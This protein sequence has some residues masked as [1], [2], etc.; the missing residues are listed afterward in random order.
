MVR[1]RSKVASR[2]DDRTARRGNELIVALRAEVS[3]AERDSLA[4]TVGAVRTHLY[5]TF[6]FELWSFDAAQNLGPLIARLSANPAVEFAESNYLITAD[7]LTPNDPRFSEQWALANAGQAGTDI[8][9]LQAWEKTTGSPAT[10]IAIIDSGVDFT[11]PDLSANRWANTADQADGQD[12]DLDTLTDDTYGW[13]WVTG[14][15]ETNYGLEHGT[16][17]AGIIAAHGNN[18]SGGAGVMW[19]ASLM[20]L[21]VLDATGTGDVARAVESVNYAVAHGAQVINCSWGTEGESKALAVALR[22]AD[23]KGVVIVASAGNDGRN[24]DARP[25]YPAAYDLPN[26]IAVAATDRFDQLTSFSNWGAGHAAIAAPGDGLLTTAPSGDYRE[27]SGT[28]ISAALV[29]GVAGLIKTVRPHLGAAQVRESI[30]RGARP[31]VALAGRATSGGVLSVGDT[32]E[33]LTTLPGEPGSDGNRKKPDTRLGNNGS[34]SVNASAI[35]PIGATSPHPV[36]PSFSVGALPNLDQLRQGSSHTPKAPDA[37]PSTQR[38]CRPRRAPCE[39]N[40]STPASAV[41][42]LIRAPFLTPPWEQEFLWGEL[43]RNDHDPAADLPFYMPGSAMTDAPTPTIWTRLLNGYS[44]LTSALLQGTSTTTDTTSNLVAHWKLDESIGTTAGD[45]TGDANTATLNGPYWVGG[46]AGTGALDLNGVN[47]Y[48]NVASTPSI[49]NIANNFTVS[50]WA[51]PRTTHQIDAEGTTGWDGTAGQRYAIEPRYHPDPDAGA[52][53][54]VGTN[55]VS[56]YEHSYGYMPAVLVHQATLTGWT[57]VTVVYQN[58]QPR[59]Y[60]NGVLVRT[61]LTSPRAN[62]RLNPNIGGMVYGYFDGRLDDV[63]IYSRALAG[64]DV[65]ALYSSFSPSTNVATFTNHSAAFDGI[66]GR[67]LVPNGAS[68]NI[69]G[70]LTVEGWFKVADNSTNQVI[71]GNQNGSGGYILLANQGMPQFYLTSN[72]VGSDFAIAWPPIITPGEWHHMAGVADGSQIRVY[73]DGQLVAAKN[74]TLLPSAVTTDFTIGNG[75]NGGVGLHGNVDEVRVTAGATYTANFTPERHL[76]PLSGTRGLWKFDGQTLLDSSG[77]GNN[78]RFVGGAAYSGDLPGVAMPANHSAAFDGTTGRIAVP[79]SAS[80]NVTGA[81]TVEGWFKVTDTNSN[82]PIAGTQNGSG[83]YILLANAGMPQF[84]ITQGG[85]GSDFAIAWPPNITPNEWHHMAGVADGAQI[86]VYLD[87]NLVAAKNSTMLPSTTTTGFAI[88]GTCDGGLGLHGNVDEV[89]V[90]TGALYTANFTPERHPAVVAGTRGLWRLDGQT[91]L[92]SSGNGNNGSFVGGATYSA[93]V[94]GTTRLNFALANSGASAVASSTYAVPYSANTIINGDRKGAG[95]DSGTGGWNDAT[96]NAFPDWA[97]V[98]FSGTK[99]INEI[100]VF[101]IQD[102]YPNPVEPTESMTFATYGITAFEVQYWDGGAWAAVPNG[103][104][105][106]NN[107]VWRKFTFPDITTAKV[108]VLVNNALASY[109]RLTEVE[110]WGYGVPATTSQPPNQ[111]PTV[112]ITAP[113]NNATF[114]NDSTVN[115]T[116]SATDSDGTISKVEFCQNGVKLGEATTAPYSFAWNNVAPGSYSLTAKATDN[117]GASATSSAINITVTPP[118]VSVAATDANASEQGADPGVFTFTRTGGT[119]VPLTLNYSL[120]GTATNGSDYAPLSG[121]LTIPAGASAQTVNVSPIDDAAVEGNETVTLALTSNTAYA[122][123]TPAAATITIADND[124][125]PPTVSITAPTAGT[126]LTAPASVTI[127]AAAADSDGTVAKVEFYQG[128]ALLGVATVTPYA[129]S[130][131]NV[132][133]GTYSL[134]AKA[135]DNAGA[136]TVSSPI[137]VTVNEPPTVSVTTPG[138]GLY[139]APATFIVNA[140][141]SDPDGSIVKVEFFQNGPKGNTKVGEATTVPYTITM[142]SMPAGDYTISAK[143]TDDRGATMT[144]L[145]KSTIK[146]VDFASALIDPANRTGGSGVDLRSGNYNWNLPLLSLPGRAGLDLGLA[147]SCNSRVWTKSGA[148]VTYDADDGFPAPGFR[149]GFPTILPRFFNPQTGRNTYILITPNGD[150]VEL[151]QTATVGVYE[152][153]DSSYLQLIESGAT[154]ILRPPDGAQLTYVAQGSSYVC[155]KI[156]DRNGNF[157]SATYDGTG[158]IT[159]ITDTLGR[160][161]VFNYDAFDGLISISR[162]MWDAQTNQTVQRTWIT[163]GWGSQKIQ[164]SFSGLTVV[165]A[166]GTKHNVITQVGL[167]DGSLYRFDYSS[168]GQ[169]N[170][171]T[172]YTLTSDTPP[173]SPIFP[174]DYTAR[175]SVSYQL[176]SGGAESDCPRVLS[177][178]VTAENWLDGNAATTTYNYGGDEATRVW[179]EMTL[180]AVAPETA[181]ARYKEYF[182]TGWQRGLVIESESFAPNNPPNSPR[183]RTVT[184]W[185]QDDITAAYQINPRIIETNISDSEANRRRTT[186]EYDPSAFRLPNRVCEFAANATSVLRCTT[187][188]YVAA[189]AYVNQRIIGLPSVRSLFDENGALVSK[190]DYLYDQADEPDVVYLADQGAT[191]QH[192]VPE[193]VRANLNVIRQWDTTSAATATNEAQALK[194][195]AGYNTNGSLILSVDPAGHRATVSYADSFS[196]AAYNGSRFAYP[197]KVTD[198]D[199]FS[200]TMSYSFDFGAVTATQAPMPNQTQPGVYGPSR[201]M[202]YDSIGRPIQISN[203]FNSAQTRMVYPAS[204]TSVQSFTRIKDGLPPEQDYLETRVFDGAGRVVAASHDFPVAGATERRYSGQKFIYDTLGR[205]MNR[206]NLTE[207]DASWT[208]TGDDAPPTGFGWVFTAQSYDWKG[209]PTVTTNADGRTTKTASYGGCGCAGGEIVTLTD[210]VGRIQKVYHDVLGRAVKT[211]ILNPGGASVYKTTTATYNA[212]DQATRIFAQDEASGAGQE[213]LMNYDGYGR[214]WKSKAPDQSNPTVRAYNADGTTQSV[215]DARGVITN[216]AYNARHL[217]TGVSYDRH[218]MT[219][220]STE[221]ANGTSGTTDIADTP[222]VIYQYDAAGNRTSMATANGAGGSCTYAYNPL[223]QMTSESRLLPGL[224]GTYMLSYDYTIGGQLKSVTD[225]AAG[226]SFT[227]DYDAAGQITGV[228][229]TGFETATTQFTSGMKYRAWGALK[230]MAYGNG[231]SLALSYDQRGL[232]KHYGVDGVTQD[233]Q[234]GAMAHGSDFDYYDDGRV[235]YASDLFTDAQPFDNYKLHDR[236]YSY[237]H[238]GRLKEAYSGSEANQFESGTASGVLGAFRQSYAYDV[239][240]N[241]TSRTGRFWSAE[242]NDIESYDTRGR[243][244]AWEYDPD[245]R[246]I[247]RNEA[248][249]NALPY[250]PLRQAYDAVGRLSVTTQKTSR[251]RASRTGTTTVFTTQTAKAE[252][253][254]GDGVG[255]KQVTTRQV[256]SNTPTTTATYY[257]RSAVL[258]GRIISEYDAQGA[259]QQS[260]VFAGGKEV[261]HGAASL[262][263]QHRNPVTGDML[264]TNA[265]GVV[266]TK[267]MVDPMGVAVGDSDPFSS[268]ESGTGDTGGGI[269]QAQINARYAQL[270]PESSGGPGSTTCVVDGWQMDCGQ[271]FELIDRGA[272]DQCPD[273]Y[274]GPRDVDGV[275]QPLK[276]DPNTGELGYPRQSWHMEW[277]DWHFVVD[278]ENKSTPDNSNPSGGGGSGTDDD[279]YYVNHNAFGHWEQEGHLVQDYYTPNNYLGTN[280]FGGIPGS[281]GEVASNGGQGG[282]PPKQAKEIIKAKKEP[283]REHPYVDMSKWAACVDKEMLAFYTNVYMPAVLKYQV[284]KEDRGMISLMLGLSPKAWF[285]FYTLELPEMREGHE[286]EWEPKFEKAFHDAKQK[287]GADPANYGYSKD[288]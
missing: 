274:C 99:T 35:S 207:I 221:K 83:G 185:T 173:P 272:A 71:A 142:S 183:K 33:V 10:V 217:V 59:L 170:R 219:S 44:T 84:Y 139:A 248:A 268:P 18:R 144:S 238:V 164:P 174:Q 128:A 153:A 166:V 79:N 208:P 244:T 17:V 143:A 205:L 15:G 162:S 201:I 222:T 87:G 60:L 285:D 226:T 286:K 191:V 267:A 206:S 47:N 149:L 179:G 258:G 266:V 186:I 187:T 42:E 64:G 52:G 63:R 53:I 62:V 251:S 90:T 218:G 134:T 215:T 74:S 77:N 57:H 89:R 129:F 70:A 88:G 225:Q 145:T 167:P 58:K 51:Y 133:A 212:L 245:G 229:G 91:L 112:S 151:R 203:S 204:L 108:R 168:W 76:T 80:L 176:G 38:R 171:I 123:G 270:F 43:A 65:Q 169:V 239:W 236:A 246:L 154:L 39:Q 6:E 253:Y 255:I 68:L 178:T 250:E 135:T 45:A 105:T 184:S 75:W 32:S 82:M 41:G 240:D 49:T 96:G 103:N 223:S 193:G 86:R 152:A 228:S 147:L 247:S 160:E 25:R 159:K 264:E 54:S 220:V 104:V 198:P 195:K 256:N 189:S 23:E 148:Y 8:G 66:S 56:V 233:G 276:R 4:K 127:N 61:G 280:N 121:A 281:I 31:V 95:W 34:E 283:P 163:F 7:S 275:L 284:M 110:A 130:W 180:P 257:L 117:S 211:E 182:G 165:G 131:S 119:S 73:L 20:S 40:G 12:N 46:R 175:S 158:Q 5:G 19:R 37:V 109:S 81:L 202:S 262:L 98:D 227:N 237:D 36:I 97:E 209:R 199:G 101:T 106:G 252:I 102:N 200:S 279:P 22:H 192:E 24:I 161:I 197:T 30:L 120:S 27:A 107:L 92:D 150:H 85:V 146:V 190:V 28:S 93:D 100:D 16:A 155:T 188:T 29:A 67:V 26:V 21:R 271:A 242:D 181:G 230:A 278:R 118:A 196:V 9:V 216:F 234:Y 50:F 213:T 254:D 269:S 265:Q 210:E 260:H 126:V 249:P 263:W 78:G 13:D 172:R 259:R 141:A 137:N 115:L 235:K 214:L 224:T 231:T 241:K 72:G 3:E 273:N 14:S 48:L 140:T 55:G 243:N 113:A 138:N 69:N 125:N 194:S 136:S 122:I 287:C 114:A 94:P 156:K 11:H 177:K 111:P 157:I 2:D 1:P 116:A 232:L 282:G 261:A 277:S 288:P 124:T 132:A